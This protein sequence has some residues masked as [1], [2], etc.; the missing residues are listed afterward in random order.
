MHC[1]GDFRGYFGDFRLRGIN[2]TPNTF[3]GHT[4]ASTGLYE[5]V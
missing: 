1:T 2:Y 3:D 5:R 4:E